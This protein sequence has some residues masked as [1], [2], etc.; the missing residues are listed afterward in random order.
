MKKIFIS[1]LCMLYA[2]GINAYDF[3]AANTDGV[4]IYYNITSKEDKTCQVTYKDAAYDGGSY[5]GNVAIPSNV[6]YSDVNYTV[7]S[8]GDNAF[9]KCSNLTSVTIPNVILSIES[10]SFIQCDNLKA[11]YISDH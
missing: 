5:S 10:S 9:Y 3:S 1:Y 4:T 8:I 2:I 11:V 6:T 7:T